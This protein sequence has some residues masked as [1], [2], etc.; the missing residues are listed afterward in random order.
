MSQRASRSGAKGVFQ[1]GTQKELLREAH[2]RVRRH[3]EGAKLDQTV[4]PRGA[5][6]REEL[7]DAELR[8]VGVA[9]DVDQH[10]AKEPIDQPWRRLRLPCCLARD[11]TKVDF[12]LEERV[13]ARLVHA[14]RLRGGT[15]E[16]AREEVREG[17]VLVE[18]PNQAAEQIGPAQE[19]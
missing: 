8:A 3:L 9:G 2:T 10:I 16:Q 15:D 11:L 14:R 5:V 4:A 1:K 6:G 7:V 13:V 19:G 12:E 17:R 18:I